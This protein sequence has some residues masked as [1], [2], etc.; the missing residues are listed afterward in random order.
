M[1][2]SLREDGRPSEFADSQCLVEEGE[3][4]PYVVRAIE[5]RWAMAWFGGDHREDGERASP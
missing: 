2:E 3:M 5:Q 4:F 1:P